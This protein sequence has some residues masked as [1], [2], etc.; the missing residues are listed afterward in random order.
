MN[1]GELP[2]SCRAFGE[3]SGETG[4]VTVSYYVYVKFRYRKLITDGADADCGDVSPGSR[5]RDGDGEESEGGGS[6][7][8]GG[9]GDGY[10]DTYFKILCPV[11]FQGKSTLDEQLKRSREGGFFIERNSFVFKSKLKQYIPVID[12]SDNNN[13]NNND[14]N[15]H[16]A[17]VITNGTGTTNNNTQLKMIRNNSIT[18]PHRH[19]RFVR[20]IWNGKYKKTNLSKLVRNVEL[21]LTLQIPRY[22]NLHES[23]FSFPITIETS[24]VHGHESDYFVESPDGDGK[25]KLSTLLGYFKVEKFEM[26]LIHRLSVNV[27]GADYYSR[28][29]TTLF[30]R[31]F[32]DDGLADSTAGGGGGTRK[33]LVSSIANS[34]FARRASSLGGVG[35]GS[36]GKRGSVVSGGD[37]ET[38]NHNEEDN[39]CEEDGDG[40]RDDDVDDHKPSFDLANFTYNSSSNTYTWGTSLGE[41][42]TTFTSPSTPPSPNPT[43]TMTGEE[44]TSQLA[45]PTKSLLSQLQKPVMVDCGYPYMFAVNNLLLLELTLS[46]GHRSTDKAFKKHKF[47]FTGNIVLDCDLDAFAYKVG[48]M[49]DL[50]VVDERLFGDDGGSVVG[51]S[52]GVFRKECDDVRYTFSKV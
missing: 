13:N 34:S 35:V 29:E 48:E 27:T 52:D 10:Y 2:T 46:N 20:Q 47:K 4:L 50:G 15:Q 16:R 8:G 49:S 42:L 12:D 28:V 9:V 32:S 18:T 40:D 14:P 30:D 36:A 45:D 19:T 3:K 41:L 7:E 43:T 1:G 5:S 33:S 51:E 22:V 31:D 21:K 37:D 11:L 17:S 39:D 6:R 38:Q 44:S 25:I 24:N 26:R 23:L